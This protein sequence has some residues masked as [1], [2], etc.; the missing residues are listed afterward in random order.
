VFTRP[1]FS[2][3]Q[4]T[5][6]NVRLISMA[7]DYIVTDILSRVNR[8]DFPLNWQ[9]TEHLPKIAWKTGTSYGRRDAWSIGYNK[10]F[11]VGVWV[12]NFS[13]TGVADLSGANVATPLLFR[14]FNTIDYDGNGEWFSLPDGCEQRKVCS[15]TGLLPTDRCTSIVMDYFI[16]Q[17]SSMKLC[18]NWQEVTV[19]A[20]G[21]MSYCKSCA[22]ATGF[23]R[24]WVRLIEPEM[25]LWMEDNHIA[26][27][28]VP[29]HNP[30][31]ETIFKDGSPVITSPL[32]NAEYLINRKDREPIQLT[33][34]TAG[35]VS[36]VFWYVNNHFY[37]SG[38]AGQKQFFVPDE[39]PVKISCTDDKGRNKDIWI[40][41]T[42]VNL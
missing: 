39:G 27:Q 30:A 18:N 10:N 25:Q 2:T 28:K 3:A 12:G 5:S 17:V 36:R 9:A 26:F 29:P 4:D 20:D 40:R 15:E 21:K 1:R 42:Y 35:D 41:V 24:E 19:S 22:P 14:I 13:G 32:T 31:C 33:C 37:K 34:K 16:P 7:A 8:P 38:E 6:K 11:T 23:R